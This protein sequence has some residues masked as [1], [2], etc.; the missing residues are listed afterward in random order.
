M[1]IAEDKSKQFAKLQIDNEMTY[2]NTLVIG[3]VTIDCPQTR[4][5]SEMMRNMERMKM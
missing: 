2:P 4:R 5:I 1:V 3:I